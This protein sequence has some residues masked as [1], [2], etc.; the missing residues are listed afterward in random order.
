MLGLGE[1]VWQLWTYPA[2]ALASSTKSPCTTD[3][4]PHTPGQGG[5]AVFVGSPVRQF[6]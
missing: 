4:L 1:I 6:A 2:M 3:M 5:R